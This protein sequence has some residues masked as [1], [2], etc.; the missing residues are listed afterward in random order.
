MIIL[1]GIKNCDTVKKA[2]KWL[3]KNQREYRFHDLRID[4]I[5]TETIATWIEQIGW[6]TV[7]N[8]R[9]TSWRNLDNA[10]QQ[11]LNAENI[12]S[13]LQENPTLIKRPVLDVGGIISVGFNAD[14]FN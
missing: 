10:V 5:R 9:S 2:Q 11:G 7:L 3:E 14:T 12:T 13:L 1:Y 8:K 4:G 6:E